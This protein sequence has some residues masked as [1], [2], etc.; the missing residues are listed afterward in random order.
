MGAT[1]KAAGKES[2][3]PLKSQRNGAAVGMK[4]FLEKNSRRRKARLTFR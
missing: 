4:R 1:S 3:K 2:M